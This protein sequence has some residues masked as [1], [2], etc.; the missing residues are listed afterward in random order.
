MKFNGATFNKAQQDQLKKKVGA[1]LDEVYSRMLNYTGDWASGKEYHENDVVTWSTN[2]HL[3]EVIKA[4]TSS[5]TIDPSNAEYYKAMTEDKLKSTS[6]QNVNKNN[7]AALT[8][9]INAIYANKETGRAMSVLVSQLDGINMYMT[10]Y[11]PTTGKNSCALVGIRR[12]SSTYAFELCY[13]L[14][15]TLSGQAACKYSI[16]NAETMA[17]IKS[18]DYSGSVVIYE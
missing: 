12:N 11:C 18:G 5:S 1:E 6:I 13:V 2:G 14:I 3:Y 16:F 8:N 17:L 15:S 4:H 10:P 9:I 7:T